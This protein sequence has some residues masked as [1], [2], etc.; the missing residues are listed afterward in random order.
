MSL[1]APPPLKTE[2]EVAGPAGGRRFR[3]V[4]PGRTR[5]VAEDPA[6]PYADTGNA[7][8]DGLFALAIE[9]VRENS[10]DAVRA[11]AFNDGLPIPLEAFETGEMWQYVWTRDLAYAVDLGLASLDVRRCVT[12]LMYKTSGWKPSVSDAPPDAGEQQILQDTGSGGS[13]PVSTDR[14]IWALAAERVLHHLDADEQDDWVRRTLPILAATIEFD[15]KLIFDAKLGLYRGEQS[16]LDWR[17][18][19]YPN[20]TATDLLPITMSPAMSTNVAHYVLLNLAAQ[21]HARLGN[22]AAAE[23]YAG[24]AA[25]LKTA[26]NARFYD[27]DAK[28]YA[29]YLLVDLAA[30]V[31]VHRYDLLGNCLAVLTGIADTQQDHDI[32]N[33]YPTGPFGPP[34][35]WPQESTVP[36]YHNYAIWPFVTAYW[37]KA[38]RQAGHE[39]AVAAAVASM[40]H[41]AARHLSNMENLDFGSGDTHAHAHGLSGPAI[42]SRRQLWSVAGYVGLVQEV[43]LGME[44]TADGVRFRP[45]LPPETRDAYFAG[46]TAIGLRRIAY[47]GKTI[48]LTVTWPDDSAGRTLAVSRVTLNG[49][50][51]S[52]DFV[53]ADA[54]SDTNDWHVELLP[55][56]PSRA[57]HLRTVTD[58][59]NPRNVFGPPEPQWL[60][61]GGGGLSVSGGRV[62]LHYE[63]A[64][65]VRETVVKPK[66]W[67]NRSACA[68]FCFSNSS[69]AMSTILMTGCAARSSGSPGWAPNSLCRSA[70]AVS[71]GVVIV[72]LLSS[73]QIVTSDVIHRQEGSVLESD[74]LVK[75]LRCPSCPRPQAVTGSIAARRAP[76]RRWST[77]PAS[78]WPPRRAPRRPSPT[79]PTSPTSVWAPSTT[80][81]PAKPSSSTP[82]SRRCWNCM[83]GSSTRRRPVWPIP[84]RSS[85]PESGCRCG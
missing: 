21:W 79:S 10:V 25:D 1:A 18:Q 6:R 4:A 85:P 12:S 77:P 59:V 70:C 34:V 60:P 82:R 30:A 76:V 75:A 28:L 52:G 36:I 49:R 83:A 46:R 19:T 63:P 74:S 37:A 61:I 27:P 26:I 65:A 66:S 20:R 55:T 33:H 51:I 58:F 3:F 14:V 43:L 32:L 68:M 11:H 80:T 56:P 72:D 45:C 17:E 9:E 67:A 73:E 57:E 53:P 31:R 23:T 62:R 38:A 64:S 24:Y 78:C 2:V 54:L 48:D 16:F 7:L 29:G 50:T 5:T 41:A 47:R 35:V 22:A 40:A 8:F 44:T 81:S 84:R 39:R 42:N 71:A 69:H 13:Y 15:R